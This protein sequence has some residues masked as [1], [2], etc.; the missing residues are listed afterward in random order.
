MFEGAIFSVGLA[1]GGEG[2]NSFWAL[3][4]ARRPRRRGRS[5]FC[6]ESLAQRTARRRPRRRSTATVPARARGLQRVARPAWVEGPSYRLGQRARLAPFPCPT[7]TRRV[8]SF[9]LGSSRNTPLCPPP[10]PPGRSAV[11]GSGA[12]GGVPQPGAGCRAFPRRLGSPGLPAGAGPY[13]LREKRRPSSRFRAEGLVFGRLGPQTSLSLLNHLL[14]WGGD[15]SSSAG[16][17]VLCCRRAASSCWR[18]KRGGSRSWL[19]RVLSRATWVF[20]ASEE[21]R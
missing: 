3:E 21:P 12:L 19:F 16:G 6:R 7:Q 15:S 8:G 1:F 5:G 4:I 17:C 11:R 13:S 20:A 2:A 14:G 18:G 10:Q 9:G